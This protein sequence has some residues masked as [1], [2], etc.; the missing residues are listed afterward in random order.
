MDMQ[1]C[2]RL[3]QARQQHVDEAAALLLETD[4]KLDAV[5]SQLQ[6]LASA[7]ELLSL[8]PPP[9]AAAP[10]HHHT[11]YWPGLIA[12]LCL[13]L[14][15]LAWTLHPNN[16]PLRLQVQADN[17]SLRLAQ[18]WALDLSLPVA[19]LHL[20]RA[21]EVSASI[22]SGSYKKLRISGQKL[23]LKK[24][25]LSAGARLE[26]KQSRE[27]LHVFIKDGSLQGSVQLGAQ[28]R[29]ELDGAGGQFAHELSTPPGM[30]P[31]NLRFHSEIAEKQ[32]KP[33]HLFLAGLSTWNL[34]GLLIRG[35]SFDY[36]YPLHSS[37]WVSSIYQG[38]GEFL[39]TGRSFALQAHDRLYVE[40][41]KSVRFA[42]SS[43]ENDLMQVRFYGRVDQLR[44]GP[45]GFVRVHT[46]SWLEYFYHEK[47]LHL[48]WGALL[49]LWGLA[50]KLR[51]LTRRI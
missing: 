25:A 24:L 13:T 46:P 1:L 2:E 19:A 6:W 17:I 3:Q 33:V 44:A 21:G 49:F 27:G 31:E 48:L 8:A 15:M 47:Q 37:Q 43:L 42:V 51:K 30:P 40:Q 12:L 45:D 7:D 28:A 38:E 23:A 20:Q 35:L 41:V 14:V 22:G 36:E 9:S 10:F 5:N 4:S 39:E 29:I 50:W 11:W 18:D 34:P 16:N 32:G 26:L